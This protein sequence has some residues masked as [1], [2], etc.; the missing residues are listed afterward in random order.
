MP[1]IQRKSLQVETK[2]ASAKRQQ[3]IA[4]VLEQLKKMA[5]PPQLQVPSVGTRLQRIESTLEVIVQQLQSDADGY[6]PGLGGHEA[7]NVAYL[8]SGA[9]SDVSFVK[10][11]LT[12]QALDL[13][14]PTE[15]EAEV[16]KFLDALR[17]P[18]AQ[19]LISRA[20][21]ARQ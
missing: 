20:K 21:E 12:G 17:T 11:A 14:A 13:E 1:R 15:E 16:L 5:N 9:I 10:Q 7:N 19:V 8:L 4:G 3:L 2:S 6:N 18:A